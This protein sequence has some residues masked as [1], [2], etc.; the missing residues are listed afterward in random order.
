L[1]ARAAVTFA[2]ERNLERDAVVDERALLR[3]ALT[4]SMGEVTVTGIKAQFEQRMAAGEFVAVTQPPGVP[5]RAVT[6][7]EMI[8][9][10]RDTI[11]LMRQGQHTQSALAGVATRDTMAR[12]YA[13]LNEGQRAALEHILATRDQIVALE[14]VA[15]GGK[16]TALAAV[17]DAAKREGYEVQG[18]APTSR[19]AQKLEE[20]GITSSTL[21]RHLT[22]GEK[23]HDGRQRLYVL[24]ESSLASTRQMH[25][26]VR[27]LTPRDRVLLVGDVRQHQGVEAGRPYQ[28]LQEM[29]IDTVRLDE[30][31]RQQDPALKAVVEQLA[32]GQVR[33]AI[34]RLDGQGRVHQIVDRDERLTTI[35]REYASDP[36]G[37]LVV[38]PDN[39]SRR[40]INQAIHRL[41]QTAGQVDQ[42]EH[43]V[44]VLVPRQDLT[45]ADRQ[46][47]EQYKP[48]DVVRYSRGSK[49]LSIK[50]GEYA[51]VDRVDAQDN[52]LTVTRNNGA[53]VTYDP[54]R[55]QGVTLYREADRAF[56]MGDR[57]QFT[58]PD[59]ERRIAN[60]ELG[61]IERIE[62]TGR[63]HLRLDSG[64]TLVFSLNE[65]P[66]LD[67]G[68]AVTSHSSQGQTADRVLLHLDTERGGEHLVNRRLAYVAL[69][70]GRYD[71]QVYTNDK[72]R[73]GEVLNRESSHRSAIEQNHRGH[74]AVRKIEPTSSQR[75][76][77]E[78][79]ISHSNGH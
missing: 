35:A 7:R 33:D 13:H 34:Q 36:A 23:P 78:Q 58:A 37:T 43:R 57:I 24:D 72:A 66:H 30:I 47:A 68:Y 69:S 52:L 48:G 12:T 9:L 46:W 17:R 64:R 27:R 45:G 26:F 50:A 63:L 71:A 55:L 75:V 6:T 51:R 65:Q 41:R 2:K 42:G 77:R 49:V 62:A 14:G 76:A 16:T 70:R 28:Q 38:S 39:D 67:Y 54:R 10:E 59:R 15:G 60:R 32:R 4:R 3:D 20:A 53:R 22:G 79:T 74:P 40:E 21:Q 5:G 31:V 1:T 19:A 11:Q 25:E 29:G 8:A 18:F 56:A 44:R 73:L 61:T